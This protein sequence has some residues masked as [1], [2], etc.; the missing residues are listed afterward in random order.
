MVN[1][2]TEPEKMTVGGE[3]NTNYSLSFKNKC[4]FNKKYYFGFN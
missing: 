4:S 3:K 2:G 1:A